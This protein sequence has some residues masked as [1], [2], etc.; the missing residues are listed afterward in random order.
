MVAALAPRVKAVGVRCAMAVPRDVY[1]ELLLRAL[2]LASISDRRRPEAEDRT[3]MHVYKR[4]TGTELSPNRYDLL[5]ARITED[6]EGAWAAIAGRRDE[7]SDEQR[8][9]L[10]CDVVRMAMA[11]AELQD[12]EIGVFQRL[13]QALGMAPAA[14]RRLMNRVWREERGTPGGA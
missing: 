8:D 4:L 12:E 1:S 6:P 10:V 9:E 11:D 5:V 14:V 7:L 3:A 13:A 2:I